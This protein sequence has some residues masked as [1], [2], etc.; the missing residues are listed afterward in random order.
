ME[1]LLTGNMI[2]AIQALQFGLVNYVTTPEELINKT[3]SILQQ[4]ITKAPLAISK[5]IAAVNAALENVDGLRLETTLF[6]ECFATEDMK[7]GTAAFLEKRKPVFKGE[8]DIEFSKFPIL[9]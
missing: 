2:S 6:G 5:C 4:I 3:K 7:E 1:A 8:I 9:H